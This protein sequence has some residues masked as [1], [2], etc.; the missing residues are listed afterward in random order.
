LQHFYKTTE[1]Y[2]LPKHS[3]DSTALL[4]YSV[5]SK[6]LPPVSPSSSTTSLTFQ[7]YH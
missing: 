1:F 3:S 2:T 5:Y 4:L 7:Q 6:K